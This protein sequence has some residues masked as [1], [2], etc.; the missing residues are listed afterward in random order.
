L[1]SNVRNTPVAMVGKLILVGGNGPQEYELK[2]SN[3]IGR[4]SSNSLQIR[5]RIVS[6]L[7]CKITRGADGKYLLRDLNS[8]NGTYVNGEKITEKILKPGDIISLGK[9]TMRFELAA[10]QMDGHLKNVTVKPIQLQSE[11]KSCLDAKNYFPHVSEISNIEALKADYEKLRVAQALSQ[12]LFVNTDLDQLLQQ[13]VDETFAIIPAERAVILLY[14]AQQDDF[15]PRFVRQKYEEEEIHI[16][17]SILEEVKTKK[18]AVLC[19][20]ALLDER[21]RESESIIM[22]GIRSTMCVPLLYQDQLLGAMH[23]DSKITTG[24]F[25]EKDLILF[26]GIATQAAIAIQN[27]HYAKKIQTEAETRAQLQRLLSPNLVEQIV[28]G[29]LVLDKAGT[30]V[31]VTMLF[32]D[33]R[34]FTAMSERHAPEDMV[35]TLNAYF[36]VMVDVLFQH[37]GTLDKYVGD[38]IIGLFGAPVPM[39]DAPSRAVAC[40]VDMLEA[41]E[42]F[43]NERVANELEPIQVGIGVNTGSV[44]AGAI[45]SS[46]TLQYTVIGDA[47]NVASRL[48]DLAKPNEILISQSTLDYCSDRVSVK[49]RESVRVKGKL[50]PIPI[51]QVQ[52]MREHTTLVR[53]ETGMMDERENDG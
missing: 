25:T 47:V 14:D 32:A 19:S 27:Y 5:D 45:G 48:C 52:G 31:N 34:G 39:P 30:H 53:E 38:E 6:K 4:H 9:T 12:K 8:L 42:E 2:S 41:L 23:M 18:Q 17:S 20:D 3:T 40:A 7:H 21:F 1:N 44:I 13:I 51:Y 24:A 36:E 35:S 43:N 29:S 37:G 10:P 15:I 46:Q 26:S 11:V 22:Q 50:S 16:S 33:I 28:S 49:A